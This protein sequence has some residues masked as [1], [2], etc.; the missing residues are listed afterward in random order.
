MAELPDRDDDI[1]QIRCSALTSYGDCPRRAIISIIRKLI[2]EAGYDL[3]QSVQAI[4]A[5][6]G[7]SVHEGAAHMLIYK[8][9]S[10]LVGDRTEAEQ[11]ALEELSRIIENG[12]GWDPTTKNANIAEQQV[13]RMTRQYHRE[14]APTVEPESVEERLE[15]D[16]G[17]GFVLTGQSDLLARDV[18]RELSDLKTGLANRTHAPQ[19]GGYAMLNA[20]HGRQIERAKTVFL[21]R[22][23]PDK[24]QPPPVIKKYELDEIVPVARHRIDRIK[25]EVTEFKRRL[26]EGGCDPRWAFDTNCMSMLCTDKYCPA[27]G[28]NF[29]DEWKLKERIEE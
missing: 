15:A 5:G 2:I 1:I 10:G 13:V 16:A 9:H 26:N 3:R 7:T 20:S 27:W 8:L 17:D 24:E 23:R 25:R 14:I 18:K 19:L 12:V 4:A 28:S 6:V 21:K 11:C 22:V 29:C